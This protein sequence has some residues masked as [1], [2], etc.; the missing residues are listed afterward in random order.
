MRDPE[1]PKPIFFDDQ[2]LPLA[3][4]SVPLPKSLTGPGQ[5]GRGT[6]REA[7]G[8]SSNQAEPPQAEQREHTS[9]RRGERAR[10]YSAPQDKM[11][12]TPAEAGSLLNTS[13]GGVR[14]MIAR[15]ELAREKV[16]GR[17]LIPAHDVERVRGLQD[18]FKPTSEK[19]NVSP[20]DRRP[21]SSKKRRKKQR[22]RTVKIQAASVGEVSVTDMELQELKARV[23]D[24]DNIL[25][26]TDDEIR[27]NQAGLLNDE[28][29]NRVKYLKVQ[30]KK[31]GRQLQ[32]AKTELSKREERYLRQ[33][34][35]AE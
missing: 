23:E 31:V 35:R 29:R 18:E 16:D 26:F 8:H 22:S 17:W 4:S 24:L 32:K 9:Q 25:T 19:P 27:R 3:S 1:V 21:R 28:K 10:Q 15:G 14:E 6:N 20:Q 2:D 11:H 5:I 30:K 12:L 34:H 13:P 33:K 7:E